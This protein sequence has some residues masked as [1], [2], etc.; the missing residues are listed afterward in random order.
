MGT[1]QGQG[2]AE[3]G[4][5]HAGRAGSATIRDV[6][7]EAQVA[8]S[9]V[10]RALN[11]PGRVNADTQR[12]IQVVADRLGYRPNRMAKALGSRR[13]ETLALLVPD[14]TNPFFFGVIRG[15]ERQAAASGFTLVLSD[16]QEDPERER[17]NIRRLA[18]AVDGFILASARLSQHRLQDL[19][20]GH[21]IALVNRQVPGV[22]SVV[23]DAEEGTRYAVDHLA[24][25][26]HREV[27]YLAGPRSSWSDARRWR[28]VQSSGTALGLSTR[29]IGP[30]PPA[31]EAGAAAADAALAQRAGAIVAFN[32]LL[33]I[34][35]LLRLAERGI[36]VPDDVSVVGFDDIFGAEFCSPTLTTLAAPLEEV[37]RTAV[38][39]LLEAPRQGQ[40]ERRR[41][42]VLPTHLVVRGSTGPAAP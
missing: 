2:G 34:G 8:T 42:I 10:S 29:R 13:S 23:V 26:G 11:N 3:R 7:R 12:R 38:R 22:P 21:R 6:A 28:A 9:T 33:A 14:I 15:A 39:L 27:T 4:R 19:A 40:A 20:E 24:S 18:G 37:G 30:F 31:Q 36:R 5:Q 16:S 41:T 25:L 1:N 32:D 17:D 35:V